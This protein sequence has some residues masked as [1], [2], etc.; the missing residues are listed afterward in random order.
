MWIKRRQ[1]VRS[2]AVRGRREAWGELGEGPK[3]T[4][5][6]GCSGHKVATGSRRRRCH[7]QARLKGPLKRTLEAAGQTP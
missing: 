1:A 2:L 7:G 6:M 4:F 3:G 5:P